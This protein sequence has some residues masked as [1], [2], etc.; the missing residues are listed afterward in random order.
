MFVDKNV[1]RVF[2]NLAIVKKYDPELVV[3]VPV[4]WKVSTFHIR[5]LLKQKRKPLMHLFKLAENN[6][7]EWF[8]KN[9][10]DGELWFDILKRIE[11]EPK[12]K[13]RQLDENFFRREE[14]VPVD[15][16]AGAED[17]NHS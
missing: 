15:M 6:H 17:K 1:V 16:D 8:Y 9:N 13:E 5:E 4:T 3:K 14:S 7:L 10:P 11:K 2:S 12:I